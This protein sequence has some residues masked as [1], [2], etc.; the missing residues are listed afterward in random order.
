MVWERLEVEP[1]AN[2]L[3]TVKLQLQGIETAVTKKFNANVDMHVYLT[4]KHNFRDLIATILPYKGNR[5]SNHRP[6]HYQAIREYMIEQWDAEVIDGREADDEVCIQQTRC[7]EEGLPSVICG[8]DKDLW[9]CPGWHYNSHKKGFANIT[10]RQGLKHF[11]K[12]LLMGD[13]TDNIRGCW[14]MGETGAR[15]ELAGIKDEAS[16][17]AT[18]CVAYENSIRKYGEATGYAHMTSKEAVLENAR[19]LW[20]MRTEDD[21]WDFPPYRPVAEELGSEQTEEDN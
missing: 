16:M 13:M 19:L 14:K 7:A 10:E 20:M 3:H 8:I 21:V 4:G 1:V 11:Y 2:V 5:D 9:Q 17:L 6:V 18:V 12:Q 15:R